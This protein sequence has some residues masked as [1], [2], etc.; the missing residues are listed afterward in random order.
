MRSMRR[1]MVRNER[2]RLRKRLYG[3]IRCHLPHC[4]LG[5]D[6]QWTMEIANRKEP[7]L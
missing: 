7:W 4:R 5:G 2:S 1:A 3:I 6:R